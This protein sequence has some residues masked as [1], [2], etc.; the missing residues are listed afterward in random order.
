MELVAEHNKLLKKK[1]ALELKIINNQKKMHAFMITT[2]L[3]YTVST[4]TINEIQFIVSNKQYHDYTAE[5]DSGSTSQTHIKFNGFNYLVIPSKGLISS[6]INK[7]YY[8]KNLSSMMIE[9]VSGS[10]YYVKSK[11]PVIPVQI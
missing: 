4:S 7:I 8:E 11:L 6:A 1:C 9:T 5:K 2:P 10:F 3:D